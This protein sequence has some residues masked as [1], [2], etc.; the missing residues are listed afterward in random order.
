MNMRRI[1]RHFRNKYHGRKNAKQSN[2]F[3][4]RLDDFKFNN[5]I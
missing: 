4:F 2:G 5:Y 3:R 1:E